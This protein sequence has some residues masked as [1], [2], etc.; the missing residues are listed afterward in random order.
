[1]TSRT[2]GFAARLQGSDMRRIASALLLVA[3]ACATP[4]P[5]RWGVHQQR[6]PVVAISNPDLQDGDPVAGRRTFISMR[7]ID[8]H[9]VAGD[10]ELP[11]GLRAIAGP[12]LPAM[13]RT[14]AE[15]VAN[16]ITSRATGASEELFDK[17]MKDYTE[18]L[19]ARQ[20]VDIVAYLRQVR[21][22]KG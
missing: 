3:V 8:C 14:S 4:V 11:L 6:A 10:P 22:A 7:C 16:R 1:V 18:P 9:R 17:T 21:P 2:V 20:L 19:T 15:Q 12:V 13:N 5:V